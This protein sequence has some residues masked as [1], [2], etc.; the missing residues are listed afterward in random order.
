ML[1]PL[2]PHAPALDLLAIEPALLPVL[3]DVE[4]AGTPSEASLSSLAAARPVALAY[5]PRWG[6]AV[7]R[8]LVPIALLDQFAIEPR[9]PSDRRQAL[10]GFA[11][12]RDRLSRRIA[13]AADSEARNPELAEVTTYLLRARVL[14]L[15]ASGDRE[16]VRQALQDI[17]VFSPNDNLAAQ[18]VARTAAGNAPLNANDLRP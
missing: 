12:E 9:G 10:Q 18:V 8:H 14:A 11:R 3:R 2:A 13:G 15:I 7:A 17:R 6:H 16:V 4:L 5:E 1:V